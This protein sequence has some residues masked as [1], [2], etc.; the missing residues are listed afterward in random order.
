ME[1]N[2]L[3]LP[4]FNFVT[5]ISR[6]FVTFGDTKFREIK[7][8]FA[9]F[10]INISKNFVDHP[11]EK[12]GVDCVMCTKHRKKIV[13]LLPNEYYD[14]IKMFCQHFVHNLLPISL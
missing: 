9:K 6:N 7:N 2:I 8:Y 10:E 12:S 5:K 13:W 4:K 14:R 11:T 1:E 3:T